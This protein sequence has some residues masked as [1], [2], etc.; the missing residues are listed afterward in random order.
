[1]QLCAVVFSFDQMQRCHSPGRSVSLA[2]WGCLC[3]IA[4]AFI[5]NPSVSKADR[6]KDCDRGR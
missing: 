5:E 2:F 1:M 6:R 3:Y 4:R